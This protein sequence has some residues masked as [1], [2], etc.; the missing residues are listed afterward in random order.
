MNKPSFEEVVAFV[1]G[2]HSI[3]PKQAIT[4]DTLLE[5]DLGITGDDGDD[6]LLA[7]SERFQVDL[8]SPEKGISQ[9]LELRPNEFLF[10]PEG[11]DPIGI[12]VLIRWLKGEPR[13]IYRDLT[14]GELHDAIQKAPSSTSGIRV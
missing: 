2:F 3:S 9:T 10:G 14:I 5:A 7:V 13:P 4:S 1:R 6:L 8:A 12:T 11:F